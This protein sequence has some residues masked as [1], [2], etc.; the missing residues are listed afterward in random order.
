MKRHGPWFVYL[1][2]MGIGRACLET[3]E[4]RYAS[5]LN[6]REHFASNFALAVTRSALSPTASLS[7]QSAAFIA[8]VPA[9]RR[10]IPRPIACDLNRET[11]TK[12][13][14]IALGISSALLMPAG[15]ASSRNGDHIEL[16]HNELRLLEDVVY[17]LE[18]EVKDKDQQINAAKRENQLIKEEL[19]ALSDQRMRAAN[20]DS[21]DILP[22]APGSMQSIDRET[23]PHKPGMM[24][25]IEEPKIDAPALPLPPPFPP[26][27]QDGAATQPSPYRR[28]QYT[29]V[30]QN[31]VAQAALPANGESASP[32]KRNVLENPWKAA[33]IAPP[34]AVDHIT[35]HPRLSGGHNTDRKPGDDGIQVIFAPRDAQDQPLQVRGA[36]SVVLVDPELNARSARWEFSTDESQQ[37]FKKSL[38]AG[39]AY[40]LDLRWPIDAPTNAEQEL[41][42][43]FTT[44]DGQRHEAST[45]IIL[46]IPGAKVAAPPQQPPARRAAVPLGDGPQRATGTP[47]L[48]PPQDNN[49]PPPV[50]TGPSAGPSLTAPQIAGSPYTEA[51]AN[52]PPAI[53]I[54]VPDIGGVPEMGKDNQRLTIAQRLQQRRAARQRGESVPSL[55]ETGNLALPTVEAPALPGMT[56]PQG[57]VPTQPGAMPPPPAKPSGWRSLFNNNPFSTTPALTTAPAFSSAPPAEKPDG[58]VI[59]P[60]N[61]TGGAAPLHP[62]VSPLPMLPPPQLAAPQLPN[63][64]SRTATKPEWKPY[65]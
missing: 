31:Q 36:I 62:G 46:Q 53:N 16:L 41:H 55:E 20:D 47:T 63:D 14:L 42:V 60:A 40:H 26:A 44:A 33:T 12:R 18:G 65:R 23:P 9:L 6:E 37:F 28:A 64:A 56:L 8:R 51:P 43:R 32:A 5:R 61:P 4:K 25:T 54:T 58:F 59:I 50:W 2:Q 1:D 11:R 27:N 52:N 24:G 30:E 3:S 29:E 21:R 7:L 19:K 57:S 48:A 15:C 22:A 35:I 17:E 10:S 49:D 38:L 39:E 34:S 13:A 45:K